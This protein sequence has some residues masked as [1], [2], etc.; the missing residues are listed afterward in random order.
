MFSCLI[1]AARRPV[2]M[3]AS[4]CCNLFADSEFLVRL[5]WS[6]CASHPDFQVFKADALHTAYTS[7]RHGDPLLQHRGLRLRSVLPQGGIRQFD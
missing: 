2:V 6:N 4:L 3:L 5:R 7:L 1:A